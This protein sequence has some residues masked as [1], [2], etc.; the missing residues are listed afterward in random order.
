MKLV[1][2]GR[3]LILI[4]LILLGQVHACSGA[5]LLPDGK[6]CP[7]CPSGPCL[8]D[9]VGSQGR[10]TVS[11]GAP[12]DCHECCTL[13]S[14]PDDGGKQT[15]APPPQ[16]QPV[17]AILPEAICLPVVRCVAS[18]VVFAHIEQG[19]PNAPPST[20][21]SRAPPFQLN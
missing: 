9:E 14:C 21:S 18:K 15:A 3:A 11:T 10:T 19:F 2:L 20:S 7:T 16:F 4:W 13:T 5:W 17:C 1:P 12:L 8:D 6:E